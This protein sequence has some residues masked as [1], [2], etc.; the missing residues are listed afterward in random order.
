MSDAALEK[1]ITT[2]RTRHTEVCRRGL[3][4]SARPPRPGVVALTR[5]SAHDDQSIEQEIPLS[6]RRT[7]KRHGHCEL[8][9]PVVHSLHCALAAVQCIVIGP[10]CL[11]VCM[12]VCGVG[13]LPR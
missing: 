12:G 6:S 13:L 11:C 9:T 4:V 3:L 8:S 2:T 10:V 5:I 7:S 1:C